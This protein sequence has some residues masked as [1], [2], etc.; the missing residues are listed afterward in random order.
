MDMTRLDVAASRR[1]KRNLVLLVILVLAA[2]TSG[3][4]SACTKGPP[5]VPKTNDAVKLGQT[6]QPQAL[7]ATSSS[8]P[9][10]SALKP[11][12]HIP[13]FGTGGLPTGGGTIVGSAGQQIRATAFSVDRTTS[14]AVVGFNVTWAVNRSSNDLFIEIAQ[15]QIPGHIV[16]EVKPNDIPA[17][18]GFRRLIGT[19]G[20]EHLQLV[21]LEHRLSLKVGP[22]F[23]STSTTLAFLYVGAN[24]CPSGKLTTGVCSL[25]VTPALDYRVERTT[26]GYLFSD[27][28][29]SQELASL[30]SNQRKV[31]LD[32]C[33]AAGGYRGRIEAYSWQAQGSGPSSGTVVDTAT[34]QECRASVVLNGLGWWNI[35]VR[36]SMSGGSVLDFE[37]RMNVR[38]IFIVSVGDSAA[39][40][41]GNPDRTGSYWDFDPTTTD[42]SA[43]WEDVACHRSRQSF[44]TRAAIAI[45]ESDPRSTVSYWNIACSGA[46]ISELVDRTQPSFS[47]GPQL[48]FL[49][50]K[51]CHPGCSRKIDVLLISAGIN[52]LGMS[53]IIKGCAAAGIHRQVHPAAWKAIDSFWGPFPNCEDALV[54]AADAASGIPTR[55]VEMAAAI[56]HLNLSVG[57]AI[58]SQ[59]PVRALTDATGTEGGC[60]L[61]DTIT[62]SMAHRAH[63]AGLAMNS[64]IVDAVRYLQAH[65]LGHVEEWRVI[66]GAVDAFEG[67]GYCAKGTSDWFI[68]LW[69]SMTQQDDPEG[70]LHPNATGHAALARL[71]NEQFQVAGQRDPERP[72]PG[73]LVCCGNL[74][75]TKVVIK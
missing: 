5:Q 53:K 12:I 58:L 42:I 33:Y 25:A 24:P 57:T 74:G 37:Y 64:G 16:D 34:T 18:T 19:H 21:G 52:D 17:S 35:R 44:H 29:N 15:V 69:E 14:S 61:L 62:Q 31:T 50:D 73:E 2:W 36:L 39:S 27:E 28:P 8:P 75:S 3:V 51:L 68:G 67:H 47:H 13:P 32:S 4:L 63:L 59:Y 48:R 56:E 10:I 70:T 65:P 1:S 46:T 45:D 55:I 20:V 43:E 71:I 49:R 40:G 11:R 38:D 41:E 26:V 60:D 54:G 72:S 9:T 30:L 23:D 66:T 6:N 22:Q 7:P